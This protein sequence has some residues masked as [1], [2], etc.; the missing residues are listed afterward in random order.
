MPAEEIFTKSVDINAPDHVVW[1]ALTN[2]ELMKQWM[3]EPEM[4]LEIIT[5]WKIRSPIVF[6]GFHHAKFE[7]KGIVLKCEQNK[8]LQYTH[9]SSLSRLPDKPENYSVLE[10]VLI[11]SD[12]H[13]TLVLTIRNF[14]TTAIFKHLE[15]YW[16][17]TLEIFKKFAENLPVHR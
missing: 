3:A 16:A 11:P 6:K 10:F 5:D 7:N 4:E 1:E 2:P 14:P 12:I 8:I 13:T 17:S 15:F 9:S